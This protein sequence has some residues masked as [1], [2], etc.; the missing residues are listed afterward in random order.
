MQKIKIRE[1]GE[2]FNIQDMVY[3]F[4]ENGLFYLRAVVASG[5][6]NPAHFL[7]IMPQD[8]LYRL[9]DYD[10]E[11]MGEILDASAQAHVDQKEM[12]DKIEKEK[13]EKE[14]LPADVEF[15]DTHYG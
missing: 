8:I 6:G 7:S 14:T 15:D 13:I 5:D 1:T 9:S 10:K 3:P 11:M 12:M 2:E 4:L